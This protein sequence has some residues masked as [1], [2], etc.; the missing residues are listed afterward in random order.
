VLKTKLQHILRRYG[1]YDRFKESFA[2]DFYRYLRQ[3]R[4]LRWR[5]NEAVSY[6]SLFGELPRDMLVFDVGAHRGQRTDVFLKLGARVVAVEPDALNQRFLARKYS[7]SRLRKKTVTIVNKAVSDTTSGAVMWVHL[8]GSGLNSLSSKWVRTLER[9]EK[10]FGNVVTF[11]GS[12]NVETVTIESLIDSFGAPFYIKID[13]EG[14]EPSVL[15]GLR[16]A[17]PYLSFEVNLPEFLPEGIE[18]VEMLGRLAKDGRFNLSCDFHRGLALSEWLDAT[19]VASVLSGCH[20]PS[21]EVFWKSGRAAFP[22]D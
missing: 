8:P 2:Y 16:R 9:D 4:P 19:E 13:V 5:H 22:A 7:R 1:L 3:G 20:A 14:H 6:R 15:R 10:R 11:V 18:C 12:R 17:V 21:V